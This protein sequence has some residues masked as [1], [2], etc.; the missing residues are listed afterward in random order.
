MVGAARAVAHAVGLSSHRLNR[1]SV[2]GLAFMTAIVSFPKNTDYAYGHD[3][4]GSCP[5]D[6]REH[7]GK[8]RVHASMRA[9]P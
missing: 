2:S 8:A 6:P 1:R 7:T 5:Q 4:E 9:P 3:R